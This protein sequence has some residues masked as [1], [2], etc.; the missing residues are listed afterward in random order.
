MRNKERPEGLLR[1]RA[2]MRRFLDSSDEALD[3]RMADTQTQPAQNEQ[4]PVDVEYRRMLEQEIEEERQVAARM[5]AWNER[6]GSRMGRGLYCTLCVLVCA[7]MI[8]LFLLLV[9]ALPEYGSADH[10]VNNEV[11]A[12]YIESGLQ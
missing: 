4:P 9:A 2:R 11:S 10:P 3:A 7:A 1:A 5:R 6:R 12:R 8:S